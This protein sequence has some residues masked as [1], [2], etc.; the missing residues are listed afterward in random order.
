MLNLRL[1]GALLRR[2]V[3][4]RDYYLPEGVDLGP[5]HV[6]A[7]FLCVRGKD[8]DVIDS[9]FVPGPLQPG[10]AFRWSAEQAEGIANFGRLSIADALGDEIV[11]QINPG[12]PQ[13]D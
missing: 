9:R 5:R 4:A 7:A 12:L 13:P 2:G 6:V 3:Q 11:G 1:L 10:Q 8:E